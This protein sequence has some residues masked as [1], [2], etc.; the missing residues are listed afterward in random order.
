M[1]SR[2][3]AIAVLLLSLHLSVTYY[4]TPSSTE[5]LYVMIMCL[6][7]NVLLL[8][9]LAL[10]IQNRITL[11]NRCCPLADNKEL[12]VLPVRKQLLSYKNLVSQLRISAIVY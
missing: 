1:Q 4:L 3:L 12:Q 7:F 8:R 6:L 5:I 2:S 9:I 11:L 10:I